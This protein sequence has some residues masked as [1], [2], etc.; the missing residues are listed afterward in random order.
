MCSV[1]LYLCNGQWSPPA[2]LFAAAL[3]VAMDMPH[4]ILFSRSLQRAHAQ[5]PGQ[6]IGWRR[7]F[8]PAEALD[9]SGC[10]AS[11]KSWHP[12]AAT[13]SASTMDIRHDHFN[14]AYI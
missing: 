7:A 11:S 3:E 14:A 8:N 6:E 13:T 1:H 2:N 5:Y 9:L 10:F 12:F 4:C